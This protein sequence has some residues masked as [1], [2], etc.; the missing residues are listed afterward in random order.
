MIKDDCIGACDFVNNLEG[1]WRRDALTEKVKV[2]VYA[3]GSYN[4][5]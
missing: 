4:T 2:T 5:Q 3:K 1:I